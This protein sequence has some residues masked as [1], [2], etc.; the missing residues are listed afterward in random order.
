MPKLLLVDDEPDCET[1]SSALELSGLSVHTCGNGKEAV[2]CYRKERVD[3]VFCDLKLPGQDG[4]AVLEEIKAMDPWATVIIVTAY[5]S[6]DSAAHALRLGAYDF[7]EKPLTF[8]KIQKAT[9]RALDHRRALREMKAIQGKP[10][11]V[12]D[13]PARLT[14]LEELKTD[15]L[16]MITSELGR[17]L[18]ILRDEL[19]LVDGGFYGKELPRQDQFLNQFFRAYKLLDRLMQSCMAFSVSHGKARE[20][21]RETPEKP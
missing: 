2:A 17:P 4:L 12:A 16:S 20:R 13:I 3:L 21:I 1:I 6:V 11:S 15:F 10:G 8:S 5:G 7:L 18:K 14:E 9:R 19:N